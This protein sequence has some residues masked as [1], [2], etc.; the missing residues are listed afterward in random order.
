M[1]TDRTVLVRALPLILAGLQRKGLEPVRLDQ[2][3]GGRAYLP[4]C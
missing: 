3:L 4:S 2:L 1:T